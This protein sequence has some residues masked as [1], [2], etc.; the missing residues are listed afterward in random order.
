MAKYDAG[1]GFWG[2]FATIVFC[3]LLGGALVVVFANTHQWMSGTVEY[4]VNAVVYKVTLRDYSPTRYFYDSYVD[5]AQKLSVE[6]FLYWDANATNSSTVLALAIQQVLFT[7]GGGFSLWTAIMYLFGARYGR[8]SVAIFAKSATVSTFASLIVG[9]ALYFFIGFLFYNTKVVNF[10]NKNGGTTVQEV[11]P[12][13][14]GGFNYATVSFGNGNSLSATCTGWGG[15]SSIYL[16]D[17]TYGSFTPYDCKSNTF[18]LGYSLILTIIG[19]GF[20][21]LGSILGFAAHLISCLGDSGNELGD[22]ASAIKSTIGSAVDDA[23]SAASDAKSAASNLSISGSINISVEVD[24][25][26]G[27]SA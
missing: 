12:G 18:G 6:S 7:I 16:G 23:K 26:A 22:G 21:G 24:A 19:I 17:K 25:S 20:M 3:H 14:K 10:N 15:G 4:Q 27:S 11:Y 9:G 5:D 8:F 13:F 2:L 1:K